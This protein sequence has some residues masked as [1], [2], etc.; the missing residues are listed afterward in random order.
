[1]KRKIY[2]YPLIY[3]SVSQAKY[4]IESNILIVLFDYFISRTIIW[5]FFHN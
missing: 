1:M 5:I 3:H 4:N 2:K